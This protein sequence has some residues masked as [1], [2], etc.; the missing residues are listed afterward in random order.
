MNQLCRAH[1]IL[2]AGKNLVVLRADISIGHSLRCFTF[3]QR[4]QG[5]R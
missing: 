2:T 3:V 1:I 5:W 4:D